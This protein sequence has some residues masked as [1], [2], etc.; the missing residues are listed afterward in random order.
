M[1]LGT[2]VS[3]SKTRLSAKS[4]T[5]IAA[6]IRLHPFMQ[7]RISMN[8][9]KICKY[10]DRVFSEDLYSIDTAPSPSSLKKTIPVSLRFF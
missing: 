3:V 4:Y 7:Q 8:H 2:E 6:T 10:V 1:S 5:S 9:P